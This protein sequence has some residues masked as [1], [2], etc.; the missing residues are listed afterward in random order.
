MVELKTI[1][2]LKALDKAGRVRRG[3]AIRCYRAK[4]G[5]PPRKC[6]REK[7]SVRRIVRKGNGKKGVAAVEK[8]RI[9]GG[10]LQARDE[11]FLHPLLGL[12]K[13]QTR[14]ASLRIAKECRIAFPQHSGPNLTGVMDF[15]I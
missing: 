8:R 3:V 12:G 4:A 1:S 14:G 10:R 7:N 2:Q 6:L 5:S 15:G 9:G 11:I 13:G